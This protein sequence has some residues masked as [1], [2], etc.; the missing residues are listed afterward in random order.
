MWQDLKFPNTVLDYGCGNGVLT[1]L[2]WCHGFGKNIVGVDISETGLESAR[3]N[4]DCAGLSF[5][6]LS[7]LADIEPV[8]FEVAVSSHV[9]EHVP[10]AKQ[11]WV[12]MAGKADWVIVEV[13]LEDCFWP[14][15]ISA[16]SQRPR[17]DNPLGHVNFWNNA[18][19]KKFIKD[20]GLL[21]VRS[22]HYA[23]APF[24]IYGHPLKR[25]V[26][27]ILLKLLGVKLYGKI[28][29]TH[30]ILLARKI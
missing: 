30:L 1:Y 9:L 3:R 17:A 25:S 7:D 11:A 15:F 16:I 6:T 2:L 20:N 27:K 4:F 8:K 29:A 10:D 19:F 28:F 24:S 18:T 22:Y 21:A 5:R 13:P 26:Q 12:K 23:S 14:N